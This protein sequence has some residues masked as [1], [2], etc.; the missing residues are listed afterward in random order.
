[1]RADYTWLMCVIVLMVF[2]LSGAIAEDR[3]AKSIGSYRYPLDVAG[4]RML[5][6]FES[7]WPID[8]PAQFKRLV[9]YVHGS[10]HREV[11]HNQSLRE[12]LGVASRRDTL[13]FLPQFLKD[14]D[15]AFHKLP[16]NV[17]SWAAR[18]QW[19]DLSSGAHR[20]SSFE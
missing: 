18:W 14:K 6:A 3:I 10:G 12:A 8:R 7:N 4:N 19:G 20:I 1:M 15:R 5:L 11:E 13:L 16:D 2:G 9:F 17:L